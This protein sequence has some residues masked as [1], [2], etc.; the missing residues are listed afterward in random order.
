MDG[1]GDGPI[2]L[3]LDFRSNAA[4]KATFIGR[5]PFHEVSIGGNHLALAQ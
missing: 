2:K 5:V 3:V 1:R 4:R